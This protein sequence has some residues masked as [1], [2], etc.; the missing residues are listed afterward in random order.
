MLNHLSPDWFAPV[1]D[2]DRPGA[3]VAAIAAAI[4]G[5]VIWVIIFA[6]LRLL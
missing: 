6:L 4:V 3:F 2:P 1:E 5:A